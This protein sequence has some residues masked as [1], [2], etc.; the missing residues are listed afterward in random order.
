[1][2]EC[3]CVQVAVVQASATVPRGTEAIHKRDASLCSAFDALPESGGALL[4]LLLVT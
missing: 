2:G 1:M 4:L 3:L